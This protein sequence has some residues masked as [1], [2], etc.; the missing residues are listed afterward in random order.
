MPV[1][2]GGGG[3]DITDENKVLII[4]DEVAEAM[5]IWTLEMAGLGKS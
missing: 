4:G 2:S 3:F 1:A 5:A